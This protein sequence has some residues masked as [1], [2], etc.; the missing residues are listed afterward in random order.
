[1]VML[2]KSSRLHHYTINQYKPYNV[3]KII[4]PPIE[5]ELSFL[6]GTFLNNYDVID[7]KL[8]PLLIRLTAGK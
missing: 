6:I 5:S 1:M 3:R 2:L 7:R 8:Q 4:A